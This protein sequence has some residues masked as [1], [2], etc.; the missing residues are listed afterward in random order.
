M[1]LAPNQRPQRTE[2]IQRKL[3]R[4]VEMINADLDTKAEAKDRQIKEV[5][6]KARSEAIQHA[7]AEK[8]DL[9]VAM[10]IARRKAFA[11]PVIETDG[12]RPDPVV[13]Q[14]AYMRAVE[15]LE[16][17]TEQ[18]EI[19]RQLQ[20]AELLNDPFLGKACLVRGYQLNNSTIVGRYF[21]VYP[22]EKP[23]WDEFMD[24]A[25]AY[26]EHERGMSFF[27]ASHRLRPLE[28]YLA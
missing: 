14:Q 27:S 20:K 21:D 16:E 23:V 26:N 25:E 24:A 5:Y 11:P 15:K 18:E 13:V 19:L 6:E 1:P 4:A 8:E 28:S 3:D 9:E 10:R 22:D 12:R 7:Q 2:D 17:F